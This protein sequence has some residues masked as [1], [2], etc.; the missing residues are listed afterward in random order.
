MKTNHVL[1]HGREAEEEAEELYN[2]KWLLSVDGGDPIEVKEDDVVEFLSGDN[3]EITVEGRKITV[4]AK[5]SLFEKPNKE[6]DSSA[7][8]LKELDKYKWLIFKNNCE[9]TAP[10]GI[11]AHS[12]IEGEAY[13]GATVTFKTGLNMKIRHVASIS[14]TLSPGG[15]FG[16]RYNKTSEAVMYGTDP[17]NYLNQ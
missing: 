10:A 9:V 4:N 1:K 12:I 17:V 3:A 6:I 16:F 5:S 15:V 8:E 7:Y 2:D 14:K 11:T 13:T